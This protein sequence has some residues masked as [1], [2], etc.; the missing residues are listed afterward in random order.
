MDGSPPGPSLSLTYSRQDYWSGLSFPSPGDLPD[1]RIKPR[2]PA[3]QAFFTIWA[4]K[5]SAQ[6]LWERVQKSFVKWNEWGC[7]QGAKEES[8]NVR[9]TQSQ[10]RSSRSVYSSS[11]F[12]IPI[13]PC[14]SPYYTASYSLDE[15]S[16]KWTWSHSVVSD[17]A[18]RQYFPG[19]STGVSCHFL[20]QRIF[21]TQGSNPGLPGCRKMLCALSH[22]GSPVWVALPNLL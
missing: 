1:P 7:S 14:V 9:I 19:N 8:A 21:P 18:T 13:F 6:N 2:S 12:P 11:K 15:R 5:Y 10:P 22:Q 4:T 16:E 17:S 20:L 3:L